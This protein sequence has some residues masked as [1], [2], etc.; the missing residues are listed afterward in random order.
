[1]IFEKN[2]IKMLCCIVAALFSTFVYAQ[3][4]HETQQVNQ[5]LNTSQDVG[6]NAIPSFYS[7]E[8]TQGFQYFSHNWLRGVVVY[9]DAPAGINNDT[10]RIDSSRFYNF[11]KFNNKLVSSQDGK[12]I[13]VIPSEAV[14]K[15]IL[16]DS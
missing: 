5:F 15:F 11:D 4:D 6:L 8:N 13:L 14:S 7:K 10:F 16:I 9:T 3:T 1:M 12:N 2:K